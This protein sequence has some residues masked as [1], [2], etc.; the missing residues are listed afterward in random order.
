MKCFLSS[1]V[2]AIVLVFLVPAG[3]LA[4]TSAPPASLQNIYGA[5]VSY[6]VNASPAVAGTALYAHL[7]SADSGTYAFTAI[8]ALPNTLKPFTVSTN[9]GAGVA[10]KVF[11]LGKV[12]FYMPTAAGISFNGSNTGWQW[13]GGMLA[14]IHIKNQY[15]LMPTV[16]FL[17]SSVSNGTG[18][19]PIV[20]VLFAWGQ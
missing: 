1:I 16:R 9:L 11:T 8:D 14:S 19:Q 15:Y 20:G 10:Q 7:L 3:V 6:S 4:Q 5:G 2:L 12:P 17:K 18:Y 13:N